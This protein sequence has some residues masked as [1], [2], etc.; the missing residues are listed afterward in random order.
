MVAVVLLGSACRT[1]GPLKED[2]DSPEPTVLVPSPIWQRGVSGDEYQDRVGSLRRAIERLRDETGSGWTGRQDEVTGYLAELSGGRFPVDGDAQAAAIGMVEAYG[3]TLF[4]IGPGELSFVSEEPA[5]DAVALRAEQREGDVPVLDGTVVFTVTEDG[6]ESRVNAIRGRVFPGLSDVPTDP[7]V[8]ADEA[9]ATAAEDGEGEAV[10]E[11]RLVVVPLANAGALAW[12]V[13]VQG[14]SVAGQPL[15]G[16]YY[17]DATGGQVLTVR[18][19]SADLGV[20]LPSFGATAATP[21]RVAANASAC[22]VE[23]EQVEVT[24]TGPN[25]DALT[26]QGLSFAGGVG[27]VDTTTPNFDPA[28]GEGAVCTLDASGNID[29]VEAP[30]YVSN[31]TTIGDPEALGAQVYSRYILDYY[32]DAHGRDSWDGEGGTLVAIVH[33]GESDFCNAYFND[34]PFGHMS[35]GHGC[36]FN[37]EQQISTF[38]E[39]DIAAHEVTH[40]VTGTSSRLLYLGQS[41][42]LNESF[43]DYFGNVIGDRYY[44]R[45]T[46]TIGEEACDGIVQDAFFCTLNPDGLQGTRYLPNEAGFADFARILSPSIAHELVFGVSQDHGGV[47]LNSAVWNNALWTIR[48]R[49]AQIDGTSMIESPKAQ[50]FDAAVYGALTRHLVPGSGFLDARAAVEAAAREVGV[51]GRSA[52]IIRQVFDQFEICPGCAA[53]GSAGIPVATTQPSQHNPAVSGDRVTWVDMSAGTGFTG[54]A[55]VGGA[56]ESAQ[57]LSGLPAAWSVGFAGDLAVTI[58][59]P[60]EQVMVYDLQARTSRMVDRGLQDGVVTGVASSSDGAA[61]F[62]FSDATIRFITPDGTVS[63]APFPDTGGFGPYTIGTG[64]G[65]VALGTPDGAVVAWTPGSQPEIVGRVDGGVAAVDTD[66]DRVVVVEGADDAWRTVMF[67]LSSGA[68]RTLSMSATPFGV[69]VDGPYIVWSQAIG[70]LDSPV[71]QGRVLFDADLFLYSTDTGTTYRVASIPGQQGYPD[72]D[73]GTL[74]WQD[75]VRGGDDIFAGRLPSGL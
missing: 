75:A 52:D 60:G 15:L 27:L 23:G 49:L 39:V 16:I 51:D 59:D 24:G 17:I 36:I 30:L 67:D 38:V 74:V 71:L 18:P 55:A 12:E 34:Q 65:T 19:G 4:G 47:H 35:Y 45:D 29:D 56:D 61:W 22:G 43:S 5:G 57:P 48:R 2:P 64:G 41:G 1:G 21:A 14:A 28:S 8:T 25:D 9:A 69:T 68:E 72:L 44:G 33:V 54:V 7:T 6:P 32:R 73:G 63:E 46:D 10:G 62:N 37:G 31:G 13:A 66:G 42:A 70:I 3:P 40:G 20:A 58:E 53:A 11:P 50:A 26:G